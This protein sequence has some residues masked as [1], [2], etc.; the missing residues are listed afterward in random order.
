MDINLTNSGHF[1][2]VSEARIFG[3]HTLGN[4]GKPFGH[5]EN[6]LLDRFGRTY[7]DSGPSYCF[8][9]FGRVWS[10]V[11]GL[12]IG[13]KIGPQVDQDSGGSSQSLVLLS[14]SV[15]VL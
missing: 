6:S 8:F 12:K 13:P 15:F 9:F 2:S 3:K 14:V 7:A 5:G 4:Q 10:P 1:I 11:Q